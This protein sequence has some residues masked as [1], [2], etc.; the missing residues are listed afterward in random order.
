MN[1]RRRWFAIWLGTISFVL[2]SD[3]QAN[4]SLAMNGESISQPFPEQCSSPEPLANA[5]CSEPT[6][7]IEMQYPPYYPQGMANA[8]CTPY[9]P[10]PLM[11]PIPLG[12]LCY[13]VSY[14]G[15]PVQGWG[16]L[17]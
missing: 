13:C 8:C 5:Q 12:S 11:T 10:C 9:A 7:A 3:G 1:I 14:Y 15:P 4:E 2:I 16:C 17:L 6:S